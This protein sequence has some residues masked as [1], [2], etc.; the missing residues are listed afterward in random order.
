[1]KLSFSYKAI[2]FSCRAILFARKTILFS[3]RAIRPVF[4]TPLLLC[5]IFLL[6]GSSCKK[7]LEAKPAYLSTTS[8][9]FANDASANAAIAGLYGQ[10]NAA[11]TF[12]TGIPL[13]TTLSSDEMSFVGY[14]SYGDM[15]SYALTPASATTNS[16]WGASYNIIYIA[17]SIL[18][19]V[20]A[21]GGVSTATKNQ[22]IGEARFIRA[23]CYFYLVNLYGK[24][25][26]VT[27]ADYA[28]NS[29]L[30]RTSVDSV[31]QLILSDLAAADSLTSDAY[32]TDGRVRVNKW[33]AKA[34]LARV[35]LYR[36]DWVDA[37]SRA[38]EVIGNN[39]V[40]YL[41]SLDN[42]FLSTSNEAVL[43]FWTKQGYTGEGVN[44]LPSYGTYLYYAMTADSTYGLVSA[45]EANDL[46]KS[47]W[48]ASETSAYDG[49]FY[50]YS[51][52]YKQNGPNG[53]N[54]EYLMVLRLAEQYLIRAE[55]LAKQGQLTAAIADIN[56]I[57]QR[58]GLNALS[59]SLS[60]DAILSAIEQER[61]VELCFEWADR[62]L[63]L[64]RT[65]R[66]GAV[67]G[68]AKTGWTSDA[69]L[70]PIPLTEIK[71]NP[72]LVQNSGY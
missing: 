16:Y 6:S 52:K 36:G 66:A 43:Q 57:R 65:N 7:A 15:F 20:T 35:Y 59:G 62:W 54:S 11:S 45:F 9:Q 21:S 70:Y 40:Y 23:F 39:Q 29:L 51:T 37:A 5:A 32:P 47:S 8:E 50:Y 44:S 64:K 34:M 19:G 30:P 17:N 13:Q 42:I 33:A 55:A 69:A 14:Q 22:I 27:G 18:G 41:E 68:A 12:T 24:V 71:N 25:P 61:R 46:R 10:I 49:N 60:S 53:S 58:A 38:S 72:N 48:V 26:L 67:L 2:L 56:A 31:Y 63:N 3:R 28:V 1:M 4:N